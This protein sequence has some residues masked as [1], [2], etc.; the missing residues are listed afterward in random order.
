MIDS[1]K[2]IYLSYDVSPQGPVPE[3]IP[4]AKVT[5]Y[6]D[7]E[8]NGGNVKILSTSTHTGTHV[9]TPNHM[10]SG[11]A[12]ISSYNRKEFVFNAPVLIDVL[13]K[14]NELVQEKHLEIYADKIALCDFLILRTGWTEIREKDKDRYAK[15]SPGFSINVSEYL[16]RFTNL[17]AI[18][19]DFLSFAAPAHVEEGVEAHKILMRAIPKIQLYEDMRLGN[20]ISGLKQVIS[21]PWIF[22]GADSA[23]CTILGITAVINKEIF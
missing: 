10:I 16:K 1:D 9:D 2:L 19:A 17:R 20:S 18:G 7:I 15:H 4:N 13:L 12:D 6:Y 8:N 5:K 21:V 22:E 3:G 11:A 14:D 23:P